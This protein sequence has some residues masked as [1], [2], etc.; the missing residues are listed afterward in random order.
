M[1]ICN[2]GNA[3]HCAADQYSNYRVQMTQHFVEEIQ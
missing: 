2:L 3:T 1:K